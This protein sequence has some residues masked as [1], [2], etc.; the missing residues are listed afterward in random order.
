ML[1]F[2]NLVKIEEGIGEKL[3]IFAFCEAVFVSGIV[4]SLTYGWELALISYVSL[5]VSSISMAVISWVIS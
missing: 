5:P 3:A 2:R 1:Y 4:I